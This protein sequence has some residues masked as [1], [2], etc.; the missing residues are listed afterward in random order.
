MFKRV[1]LAACIMILAWSLN[2]VDLQSKILPNG[3]EVVVRRDTTSQSV[4]MICVVKTGSMHEGKLMESGV[5]HYLEHVVSGGSTT[6]HPESYYSSKDKEIGAVTN[7]F[8]SFDKTAYHTLVK[9][10]SF[11]IALQM[12]AEHIQYCSFDPVEVA[13]EQQVIAKEI[14]MGST[15]P[16]SQMYW[17]YNSILYNGTNRKSNPIGK[18]NL[19]L[20]L[21]RSDLIDY[22]NRRYVPNNMIFIV[23][24]N[25]E[26]EQAMNEIEKVFAGFQPR[27]L[28]PVHLPSPTITMGTLVHQEEFDINLPVVYIDQIIPASGLQDYYALDA[29][30]DILINKQYSPIQRKLYEEMQLVNY[31][32]AYVD[33]DHSSN[34]LRLCWGFEAKDT[35]DIRKII[36]LFYNEL[37]KYQKGYFKQEQLDKLIHRYEAKHLLETKN[38]QDVFT[39]M[40]DNM[41][42]Y[43]VPDNYNSMMENMKRVTPGD[44]N[45]M[46]RKYFSPANKLTFCAIPKGEM[47]LLTGV[48]EKPI[49]TT[50][51]KKIIMDNGL[52]LV[53][54]QNNESPIVR[55]TIIIPVSSDYETGENK[56]YIEFVCD[57]LLKGSKKYSLEKFTSWTEDNAAD[58]R[59]SNSRDAVAMSFSCLSSDLPEMQKMIVDAVTNPLFSESEIK[60]LK[61][62]YNA[63]A[64]RDMSNPEEMH[65]DFRSKMIYRNRREQ[66]NTSEKNEIIQK[67]TRHDVINTYTKY[68]KA[69]KAVISIIGDLAE[70]EAKDFA[71]GVYRAFNHHGIDAQAQ[72][73]AVEV[74]NATYSQEYPFEQ[75]NLDINIKAPTCLDPDYAAVK[76]IENILSG[77]NGRIH[78][79]TR[80]DNDL[81][82]FAHA[83]FASE[84]SFGYFRVTSQ[85]SEEKAQQL[86]QALLSVLD[87]MMNEPVT[88]EELSQAIEAENI[89]LNNLI[90]DKEIGYISAANEFKGLGYD[91]RY[92]EIQELRKVTPED[93]Q[94]VAKK[95]LKDR[96]V[97][98]SIPSKDVKRMVGD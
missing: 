17:R 74:T 19:F 58:I 36:D 3:M 16:Y 47:N 20:K 82:Y 42:K 37:S 51:L 33:I 94:R 86:K 4:G 93:V 21:E 96:D 89:Q 64:L 60:L 10:E 22:Y 18:T 13:R 95:Y 14:I 28:E 65:S 26:I 54:K 88:E 84:P 75:V 57:M 53:H 50:E 9:K 79:A 48:S 12:L 34:T 23:N 73:L 55:G 68:F 5:S 43:G 92:K 80:G 11:S 76:V 91:N 85:T 78:Q 41:I 98:I 44:L 56:G 40:C 71:K 69:P 62:A 66:L 61:E 31:L 30:M 32:F 15:P 81:S 1:V 83:I 8:T 77:S 2:A 90:T 72:P 24:G 29:M 49:V 39:E 45:T 6:L 38:V 35:A 59:I 63:A 46:V 70:A 27:P 52:T 97:I 67:L 87:R 7:A 25:V